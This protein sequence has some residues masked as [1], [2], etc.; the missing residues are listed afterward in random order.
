MAVIVKKHLLRRK[1]DDMLVS[2]GVAV[3]NGGFASLISLFIKDGRPLL[4]LKPKYIE[5]VLV[6][7]S[8]EERKVS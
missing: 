2:R 1:K 6:D 4:Q 8:P 7:L 5:K 3:I